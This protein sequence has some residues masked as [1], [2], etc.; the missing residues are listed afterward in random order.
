[1]IC[2]KC[3]TEVAGTPVFCPN[4]GA[5]MMEAMSD[6]AEEIKESVKTSAEEALE[7]TEK[8]ADNVNDVADQVRKKADAEGEKIESVQD[9]ITDAF[10][11]LSDDSTET[12]NVSSSETSS[13][14][15]VKSD[16]VVTT[17]AEAT[18]V[19]TAAVLSEADAKKAAKKAAKKEK[20]EQKKR[21]KMAANVDVPK[22]Y[23]PFSTGGA[24]WYLVLA[25][26]PIVGLVALLIFAFAG[27]NR[28]RKA[29]SRAILIGM[30]ICLV[31]TIALSVTSYF[32]FSVLIEEISEA[33]DIGEVVDAFGNEL[34]WWFG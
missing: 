10:S 22:E 28:N 34:T 2:P 9:D 19:A 6:A 13:N 26:I 16:R 7:E 8:K 20:K 21:D 27:K 3:K 24:F 4:C 31:I 11:S 14:D 1:M 23:K 32:V 15:P 30:L 33:R 25:G 5:N 12:V 18:T 17:S 29:M